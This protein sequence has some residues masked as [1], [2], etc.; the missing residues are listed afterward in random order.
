MITQQPEEGRVYE[1]FP[2]GIPSLRWKIEAV[3][4]LKREKV[5]PSSIWAE[6]QQRVLQ[7]CRFKF[8]PQRL[9]GL[10]PEDGK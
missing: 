2:D 5:L 7:H 1:Q 8:F 3:A 4:A 10:I 6:Y 9:S